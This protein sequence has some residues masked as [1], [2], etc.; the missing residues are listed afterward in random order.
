MQ[1]KSNKPQA[2]RAAIQCCD[3]YISS[4]SVLRRL[5]F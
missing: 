1:V 3:L 4:K 2:R 5:Q